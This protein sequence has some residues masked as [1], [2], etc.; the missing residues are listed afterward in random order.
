MPNSVLSGA[1]KNYKAIQESAARNQPRRK[2]APKKLQGLLTHT[3][4]PNRDC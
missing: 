2:L 3:R 1:K 4:I